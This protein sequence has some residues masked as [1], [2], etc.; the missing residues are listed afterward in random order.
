[1]Q[2]PHGKTKAGEGQCFG[3]GQNSGWCMEVTILPTQVPWQGTAAGPQP[4]GPRDEL[5]VKEVECCQGS[6]DR[7]IAL[8]WVQNKIV[9][10]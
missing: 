6:R 8:F 4:K 2:Q 5:N 3:Q 1:M 7:A 10:V 9:W